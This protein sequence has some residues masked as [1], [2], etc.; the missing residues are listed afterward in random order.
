MATRHLITQYIRSSWSWVDT[1][2]AVM[3]CVGLVMLVTSVVVALAFPHWGT[4]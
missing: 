1:L 4:S 3:M 2:L